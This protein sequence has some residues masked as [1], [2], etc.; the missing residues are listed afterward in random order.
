MGQST[1][2]LDRHREPVR[3]LLPPAGERRILRPPVEAR[4][5]LDGVEFLDVAGQPLGRPAGLAGTAHR[6]S[7]RRTSP[8][9][10]SG[11]RRHRHLPAHVRRPATPGRARRPASPLCCGASHRAAR[12]SAGSPRFGRGGPARR[13]EVR[14]HPRPHVLHLAQEDVGS[15]VADSLELLEQSLAASASCSLRSRQPAQVAAVVVVN[16]CRRC[17]PAASPSSRRSAT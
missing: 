5:E 4:V 14:P 9:C 15:G 2:R 10:R 6:S 16:R 11:S 12:A 8:R 1:V 13:V 7:G 3:Q 17:R